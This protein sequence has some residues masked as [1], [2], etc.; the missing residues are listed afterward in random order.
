MP[1]NCNARMTSFRNVAF[2]F[3]DS[4]SVTCSAGN[5]SLIGTPGEARAGAEVGKGCRCGR[6][7]SDPAHSNP[8]NEW[9]SRR[10]K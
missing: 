5:A 10:E 8:T 6:S 3:C 7:L 2:L 9:G 4:I 1:S